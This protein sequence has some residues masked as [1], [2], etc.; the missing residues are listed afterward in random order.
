MTDAGALD[1]AKRQ[2]EDR[3]LLASGEGA[4]G[5]FDEDDDLVVHSGD[6]VGDEGPKTPRTPGRVRFDLTPEVVGDG[7]Y[8]N[9]SAGRAYRDSLDVEEM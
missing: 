4:G 6:A 9:G 2:G 1:G 7:A 3:G 8:T 5:Y